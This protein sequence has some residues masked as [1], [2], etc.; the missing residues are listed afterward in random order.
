MRSIKKRTIWV[1]PLL[2]TIIIFPL[3]LLIDLVMG[4]ELDYG[5][6]FV[7]AIIFGGLYLVLELLLDYRFRKKK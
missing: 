2:I 4:M 3:S 5:Y 7:L 6:A 1:K